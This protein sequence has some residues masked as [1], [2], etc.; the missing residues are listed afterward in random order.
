MTLKKKYDKPIV[1]M[2]I[3]EGAPKSA[4]SLEEHGIIM[5]GE[6]DQAA[7]ALSKLVWYGNY[8]KEKCGF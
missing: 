3:Y 8:I 7:I 5:Y 4:R 2:G 1:T 6:P